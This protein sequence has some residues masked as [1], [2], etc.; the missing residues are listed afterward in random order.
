MVVETCAMLVSHLNALYQCYE[1]AGEQ[2]EI[3][4]NLDIY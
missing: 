1:L 4:N 2:V 3:L